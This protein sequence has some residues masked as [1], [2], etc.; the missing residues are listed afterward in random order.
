MK[1]SPHI[2]F[3]ALFLLS[4][5]S[6]LPCYAQQ[7]QLKGLVT[8]QNSKTNTGKTQFVKNAEIEHINANHA[9]T[10]DVT[11]DDG[12]FI[13]NIKGVTPNTQIQISVT[14]YG[15]FADYVVVNEKELKDITLG[16][17][18]PVSVFVCKKGELEQRQAEMIGINMRKLEERMEMDKKRLQK[19]L[20]IIRENN[21]YLNVRYSEI[22]DSLDI[23]SKNI[24]NAFERIKEYAKTLTLE[25]LDERDN[26]YVKAY[27]CFSRGELDSVFLYL[28]EHELDLKYMEL[29]QLQQETQKKKEL[30]EVLSESIRAEE[31]FAQNIMNELIK[32]WLLLARTANIQND[33]KKTITYYEKVLNAD[34]LNLDYLFEFADY[35][36]KT[37]DYTKSEKNYLQCLSICRK[38][39]IVNQKN[40]LPELAKSLSRLAILHKDLNQFT[41]ALREGDEALFLHKE[42][43]AEN[44][45]IYLFHVAANLNTLALLH[46]NKNEYSTALKEFEEALIIFRELAKENPKDY[47]PKVAN[48][49]HNLGG[50]HRDLNYYSIALREYEEALQI[51]R[52][53]AADEPK[54]YLQE[55]ANTLNDFA[56]FHNHYKE[57]S[58]ALQKYKEA[59]QIRREFAIENP[60]AFLPFVAATLN[61]LAIL[62][63]NHKEYLEAFPLYEEA[64]SIRKEIARENPKVFL[65]V[66]AQTLNN[67][68]IA[69]QNIEY[70]KSMEKYEEALEINRKLSSEN[71]KV[72]LSQVA[73]NLHNIGYLYMVNNDFFEAFSKFGESLEIRRNLSVEAP[74]KFLPEVAFSLAHLAYLNFKTNR[75]YEALE[76]SKEI[77]EIYKDLSGDNSMLFLKNIIEANC[78]VSLFSI[79]TKEFRQ[80]EHY[81]RQALEIDNNYVIAKRHLANSLLFQNLISEAETIFKD[82]LLTAFEVSKKGILEDF[83]LFDKAN[84]IPEECKKNVEKIKTM[85][86]E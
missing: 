86:L 19:E 26:N 21:D 50:V 64:L 52:E 72:Y 77:L 59:L 16:R 8:V 57:Y 11:G 31:E 70:S 42:L 4:S 43:A 80:A 53:L 54:K 81:A 29:F 62:F 3:L 46:K 76:L 25:N 5:F 84:V 75:F 24:D 65:P 61:N 2:F 60:K 82:I 66:V 13:L 45:E 58:D 68:A 15:N 9:K 23:I 33:Y 14:L 74:K 18:A 20:G 83:D 78:D 34:S 30:V 7:V 63:V 47:L 32:Q 48:T 22:K 55:V 49:L 12:K 40:N 27:K 71:P 44:P 85:L 73:L 38:R 41:D 6:F 39:S 10:K 79:Y 1:P 51:C 35:L 37:N 67:L 69:Y 56:N 36:H 17:L 28:P